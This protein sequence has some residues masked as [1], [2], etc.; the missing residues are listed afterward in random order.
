MQMALD[1]TGGNK[2]LAARRL[3]ISR[4][5]LYRLIDKYGENPA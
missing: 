4:R 2:S 1:D 3:G 5:T